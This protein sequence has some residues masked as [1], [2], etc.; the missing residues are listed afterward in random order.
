MNNE[1]IVRRLENITYPDIRIAEHQDELRASLLE[2]YPSL[3]TEKERKGVLH[4]LRSPVTQN[5]RLNRRV[6]MVSVLLVIIIVVIMSLQFTGIFSGVSGVL[7]KASAAMERVESYRVTGDGY[8]RFEY[9]NNEPVE[10]YHYEAEYASPDR[11]RLVQ[12]VSIIDSEIIVINNQVYL[13]GYA[14]TPMTP[15][16]VTERLPNKRQTLD[17]INMLMDIRALEEEYIDGVL[18]YHYQGMLDIEKYLEKMLP[19]MEEFFTGLYKPLADLLDE[20]F[21]DEPEKPVLTSLEE[22][23]KE[24][25]E[26]YEKRTRR[27]ITVIDY[28]VGKEDYLIRKEESVRSPVSDPLE[29]NEEMITIARYYDFNED[30]IIDPPLTETGELEE[31]WYV[32]SMENFERLR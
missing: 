13:K 2:Q 17:H 11:Y 5:K 31:G 16:Q 32:L 18:C 26:S 28:W 1:D 29:I 6:L 25:L 24:S 9:T 19:K 21:K 22:S 4:R 10:L 14:V 23:V 3:R 15:D 12:K 8:N 30:I 20:R 7:D 27:Y